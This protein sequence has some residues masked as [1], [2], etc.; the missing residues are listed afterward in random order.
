MNNETERYPDCD[1]PEPFQLDHKD[2]HGR[3]SCDVVRER[4]E[5]LQNA[6][7]ATLRQ[8]EASAA[9]MR[10]AE[11]ICGGAILFAVLLVVGVELVRACSMN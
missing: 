10:R 8:Q 4:W 7:K 9:R 2:A 3:D 6:Q 5:A 1:L 11:W